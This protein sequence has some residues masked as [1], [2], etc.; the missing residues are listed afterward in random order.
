MSGGA[1]LQ[2]VSGIEKASVSTIVELG[3]RDGIDAVKLQR[4]FDADKVVAFECNPHAILRCQDYLADKPNIEFVPLAAWHE[5]T[6]IP[7]FPVTNGNL[8]ASSAF[9]VNVDYPYESINQNKTT[10]DAVRLD[11]WWAENGN[12]LPI[13]LLCMDMQGSEVNALKGAGDL[14][15]GVRYIITE[16]LFKP[17]YHDAPL[18]DD[19]ERCLNDYGFKRSTLIAA[20]D[21]FGDVLFIRNP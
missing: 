8:G 1:Y 18:L 6:T 11:E 3:S 19:I 14:L 20:N 4:Y 7:F 15:H 5:T 12:G 21:W 10:V 9:L 13:D 2:F 17:L 16:C